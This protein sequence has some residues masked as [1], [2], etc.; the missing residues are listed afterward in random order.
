MNKQEKII[1]ALL[2]LAL[3]GW[4]WYSTSEQKKAAQA[5]QAAQL[6]QMSEQSSSGKSDDNAVTNGAP[7]AVNAPSIAAATNGAP[8]AANVQAARSTDASP[9]RAEA[10]TPE[11][12][13]TLENAQISISLSSHGASVKSATLKEYAERPGPISDENPAVKLDFSSSPALSIEGGGNLPPLVDFTVAERGE[14]FVVFNSVAEKDGRP[15]LSRR[16]TLKPDFQLAVEDVFAPAGRGQNEYRLSLG[17]MSLGSSKNDILSIDSW[18]VANAKGRPEVEHHGET[19]PLKSYLAASSVGGCSGSKS[20]AG[21]PVESV[22]DVPGARTWIAVKNRFFVAALVGLSG[23]TGFRAV[24]AR[25]PNAQNYLVKSVSAAA[26]F[27]GI[28]EKASYTLYIGPKR[29]ALL[30]DLGMKDVMEFGMWRWVCY[31]M[32]WVL[33]LFNSW[34]PS[35]GIAIILLTI[36]VR[37]IFWPLTHKSTISMRRMS[38]IQ[39]KIKE[40]QKKFKDNPQRLQQEMFACYRENKVNP[41]ASCL[42]MLIQIP[43]FIALFTVLRSAV[44]LRYAPFL[45]IADLSEPE[46]LGA[47]SWFPWFGGLNILPIL[48][49]VTMAL[50]SA[51]TP[52]PTM[53]DDDKAKQQRMM[54]MVLMPAMMLFMFYSFPSALSLYWTLSQVFSIVQMWWIRKKYPPAPVKDGVID[55][56]SVE[57]PVTRQMRRHQK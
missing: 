12:L 47:N 20:A 38:E 40:I 30:W 37:L 32:V 56:D 7:A 17:S 44:E 16:I 51:L 54:M 43:V 24:A 46:A 4:L 45:W 26:S 10:K 21:M 39:P 3:V 8:A 29:Q 23:N 57:M 55:P 31:P 9:S 22:V 5:A 42:P 48:M 25:D 35:Y 2:G 15:F 41:M 18:L 27:G 14:D 28:P 33:N 11:R 1:A 52:S 13:V 50:Q 19:D 36:L 6:A 49:A 53:G 34:I